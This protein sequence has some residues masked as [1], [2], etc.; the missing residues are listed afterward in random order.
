[1][2][3]VELLCDVAEGGTDLSKTPRQP[4]KVTRTKR[5]IIEFRKGTVVMMTDDGAKKWVD[6]GIAKLVN[7][8]AAAPAKKA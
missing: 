6:R 8:P 1:M 7:A 4:L 5:G 3:Q 2:P